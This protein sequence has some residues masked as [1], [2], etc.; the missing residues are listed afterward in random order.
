MTL[1]SKRVGIGVLS[2]SVMT[3]SAGLFLLYALLLLPDRYHSANLFFFL[4][5]LLPFC[6]GIWCARIAVSRPE[7]W[8]VRTLFG[9]LLLFPAFLC[10]SLLSSVPIIVGYLGMPRRI[11]T[12]PLLYAEW[13][14]IPIVSLLS[15]ITGLWLLLTNR[16]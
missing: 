7:F 11:D 3:F 13:A 5:P 16:S 15:T 12:S 1:E 4:T 9:A 6:E 8:R 10:I 2:G 14:A